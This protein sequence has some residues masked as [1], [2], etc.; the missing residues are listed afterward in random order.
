MRKLVVSTFLTLDGVMQAPGGEDEDREGGFEHG[1]W[2]MQEMDEAAGEAIDEVMRNAGALVLGRRTYDIFAGYWPNAGRE[3]EGAIA[4]QLNEMPKHVASTTLQEPLEWQ[5][6]SL[7][8][9]PDGVAG[10]KEGSGKDLLVFGSSNLVQS[11]IRHGLVD[12]FRLQI[13]P[14]VLGSGK[15]LFGE[16]L[17][18]TPLRVVDSRTTDTGIVLAT[19]HPA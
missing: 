5:N 1:G 10:L 6:S 18:K 19:Y 4:S 13:Y 9:V 14:L 15:R 17:P 7:V 3:E 12:E 16:G 11:L 2:Q 8:D